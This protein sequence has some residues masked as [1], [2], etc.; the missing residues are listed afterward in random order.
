MRRERDPIARLALLL[1][2]GGA[3]TLSALNL[4]VAEVAFGGAGVIVVFVVVD[5]DV[6]T[7]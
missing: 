7:S 6:C 1:N 4:A 3:L 5:F 2:T